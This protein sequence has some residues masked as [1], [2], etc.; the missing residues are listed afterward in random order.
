MIKVQFKL[1]PIDEQI[2][3]VK[4]FLK[5]KDSFSS[6]IAGYFNLQD[7]FTLPT[8]QKNALIKRT[9]TDLFNKNLDFMAE[10]V[11]EFQSI[12]DKNKNEINAELK[13]IFDKNFNFKCTANINLNPVCPRYLDTLS[14]D[15]NAWQNSDAMLET[16]IHEIVHFCWFEVYKKQFKNLTDAD[17]NSPS[18]HW[19]ISEIAIDP[20]FK[21]SALKKFVVYPPAYEYLYSEK[22]GKKNLM[23]VVSDF[24]KKHSLKDFQIEMYNLFSKL[25]YKQYIK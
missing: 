1:K 12:W 8:R 24:Y 10:K 16:C 9:L 21:L 4:S 5:E 11:K 15:L 7:C 23:K 13:N 3:I 17:F 14:F 18:L 25:D 19:L 6:M 2:E 20:I 22:I